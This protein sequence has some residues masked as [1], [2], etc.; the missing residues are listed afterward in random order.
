MNALRKYIK[1]PKIRQ[2]MVLFQQHWGRMEI[3]RQ[4]AE[5]AYY[6]LLALLPTLLLL[7]NIIPLLPLPREQV[8][9]YVEMALPLEVS[10]TLTPILEQYLNSG[11]SGVVS[12]GLVLSIWTASKAFN[13]FQNVLNQVYNTKMRKNFIVHRIFSFVIA[14]LL[15]AMIAFVAFLFMFGRYIRDF[16][17]EFL[18]IQLDFI[19]AFENFRWIVAFLIIAII[20]TVI[21]YVVPN[22]RWSFK[23]SLPGAAFAT[24]GF[25][26]ISQL[27]SLYV[28]VA[29]NQAIGNSAIG[30]VITLLIALVPGYTTIGIASF[31]VLIVLRFL[32]GVA[33][34]GF[35]PGVVLYLTYWFPAAYRA[36]VNGL[37][38]TSFA[39]AGAVGGPIAGAIMNGM[40][41]VGH[42]ANWQWLFILEGIPSLL[43]GFAVLLYLPEKPANA[44]WLTAAEQTAVA[45]AVA[46]ENAEGHKHASF[47]DA[48]RNYRVWLC[49]AIYFCIVSGNA[50]IAFWA[51]SIIKEIGFTNN[52]TIGLVSAIPFI[53]GT[54]AMV[55]N[56]I[57]SDKTGERR[58]HSA[59]AGLIACTGL[60]V[61]GLS[62]HNAPLALV[63]LTIAAIGILAAFPVFWS[64]PAAFLAGTAAA[65][66]IALINSIG[67]LGGYIGP[68]IFGSLKDKMGNDV[69]AVMFL[70]SLAVVAFL[71]VLFMRHDSR[72]E[73]FEIK[74]QP[75]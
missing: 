51:P 41:G 66:G 63:G 40:Q 55:W 32:L 13:V 57:H 26:L 23:Y 43:A 52:L 60:I 14:F 30:V 48:L 25:L 73:G 16:F 68:T 2:I 11:S 9:S 56:G 54:L 24:I 22:V 18:S 45:Q 21:Y 72:A 8:L 64:I 61:T 38:M 29:G 27:F 19:T 69:Y 20:M 36:R 44:K 47:G 7:G 42:F 62:L 12:F 1:N 70:A 39:I 17:E 10:N 15:V 33:E 74:A 37:F 6:V 4:S 35:F 49:A 59:I 46:A 50:T 67:N 53:A 5:M 28:G 3:G 58:M 75:H 34:A 71:L 31:W 65:G